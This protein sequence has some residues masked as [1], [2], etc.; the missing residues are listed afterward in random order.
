MK[1]LYHFTNIDALNSIL[2]NKE[3]WL[4]SA[5]E[6]N[7]VRDRQHG[8]ECVLKA[9]KQ[10][11]SILF[12]EIR[13]A[14][15]LKTINDINDEQLRF[16]YYLSSFCREDNNYLWL[17]YGKD[18]TGIAIVFDEIE[19]KKGINDAISNIRF[20]NLTFQNVLYG[21]ADDFIEKLAADTKSICLPENCQNDLKSW[22]KQSRY[23]LWLKLII[24]ICAGRIKCCLYQEENEVRLIFKNYYDEFAIQEISDNTY[25]T[26]LACKSLDYEETSKALGLWGNPKEFNGRKYYSLS[27]ANFMSSKLIRAI[28]I[29]KKSKIP[30]ENIRIMLD[31]Y[32]LTNTEILNE[33]DTIT[34]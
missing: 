3:L 11:K 22:E 6:M 34:L 27:I 21:T 1:L 23:E 19:F 24:V 15:S 32:G 2:V 18:H 5:L 14:L 17:E 10:G 12:A 16:P 4:F 31:K 13:E 26:I 30:K 33:Q 20:N 8:N 29:G 25:R 28:K 9:V 7:D